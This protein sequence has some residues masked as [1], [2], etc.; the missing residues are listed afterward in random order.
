[1]LNG[2]RN[3][4]SSA[5]TSAPSLLSHLYGEYRSQI[6]VNQYPPHQPPRRS[7]VELSN[8]EI[9]N[10]SKLLSLLML[11]DNLSFVVELIKEK[12]LVEGNGWLRKLESN[13][14]NEQQ[15]THLS[16]V[17]KETVLKLLI[18]LKPNF[19]N[20]NSIVA[21]AW[22]IQASTVRRMLV[23]AKTSTNFSIERKKR[24]DIGLTILNNKRKCES[25]I[26]P[27]RL[28]TRLKQKQSI[29]G[30]RPTVCDIYSSW[31]SLNDYIV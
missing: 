8:I 20:T 22:G 13:L 6:L 18:A 1:M 15:N 10:T 21:A 16:K 12:N 24:N 17:E 14:T 26:T 25:I 2:R 27:K 4:R 29:N 7:I 19:R 30:R 9:I 5:S 31:R 23:T 3:A 28:F 11:N